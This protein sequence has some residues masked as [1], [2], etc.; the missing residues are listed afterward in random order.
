MLE[1]L[2]AVAS[3]FLVAQTNAFT[4]ALRQSLHLR[5]HPL[6]A[7]PA[8]E[9]LVPGVGAPNVLESLPTMVVAGAGEL[10]NSQVVFATIH[11]IDA[12]FFCVAFEILTS[13]S[14]GLGVRL[15]RIP[16]C[17]HR[18]AICGRHHGHLSDQRVS[19]EAPGE[20]AYERA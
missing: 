4:P 10:G 6:S 9:V 14:V 7:I 16:G 11:Q 12:Q 8:P 18:S 13:N 17:A 5:T 20:A 19:R 15:L 1:R 3:V 2:I